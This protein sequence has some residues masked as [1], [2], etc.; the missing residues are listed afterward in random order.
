[1]SDNPRYGEEVVSADRAAELNVLGR[2]VWSARVGRTR[3]Q[4][5]AIKNKV[6]TCG[7]ARR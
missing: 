5:A 1:M 6:P 2:V 4:C 7:K 3:W